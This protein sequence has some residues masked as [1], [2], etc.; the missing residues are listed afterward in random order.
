MD[1]LTVPLT[2][3]LG[4]DGLTDGLKI[5]VLMR[6]ISP[7]Q[8]L[9]HDQ[10]KNF[11]SGTVKKNALIGFKVVRQL[12]GEAIA[13]TLGWGFEIY[14]TS[15]IT[16]NDALSEGDCSA[17]TESGWHIHR[18]INI[19]PFSEDVFETKYICVHDSEGRIEKQG[20]GVV[21]KQ[22]SVQWIGSGNLCFAILAEYDPKTKTFNEC[23]NPF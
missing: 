11:L 2:S 9:E 5:Q 22:T 23:E 10:L 18:M 20:V 19:R 1:T 6:M 7:A 14:P 12:R 8:W 17:I 16:F 15:Y 13:Q 3:F 21:V 4:Q